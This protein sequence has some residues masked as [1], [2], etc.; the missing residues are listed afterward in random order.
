MQTKQADPVLEIKS[1]SET[2]EIEGYG[3][4]FGGEPDSYGDVIA[5]GAFS[6]SLK[7][8]TAKGTMPK[9]LWQHDRNEVIGKWT[10]AVEDDHGLLIR[11]KLNMDVQRGREAYALLKDGAMDGLSI[12][13]RIAP[14][15]YDSDDETGV[16]TLKK[17]DL[18]EVSVVTIGANEN[19]TIHSVKAMKAAHDLVERLKAGDRLTEREFETMLKGSLGF[20]NSQAMRAARICL[21][22]QGEPAEAAS[23]ADFAS[24]FQAL[25]G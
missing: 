8:H 5:P 13:Y 7:A 11:G 2:G 14:N 20:S 4:T 17:L 10:G 23:A 16:W 21:K 6:D 12:G 15:G 18:F 1:L 22:G 9:M 3:S 24:A 19:A 25:M